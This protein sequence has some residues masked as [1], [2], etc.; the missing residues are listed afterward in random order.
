MCASVQQRVPFG[1]CMLYE[2]TETAITTATNAAK[3]GVI[4][5]AWSARLSESVPVGSPSVLPAGDAPASSFK[6]RDGSRQSGEDLHAAH[7]RGSSLDS[8]REKKPHTLFEPCWLLG[9]SKLDTP[10]ICC[11]AT[12]F[13]PRSMLGESQSRVGALVESLHPKMGAR[14]N[15]FILGKEFVLLKGISVRRSPAAF[16]KQG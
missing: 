15:Y 10:S 13:L 3:R 4:F 6:A 1:A 8:R 2:R 5:D 12:S 11:R 9:A 16:C 14:A 7:C